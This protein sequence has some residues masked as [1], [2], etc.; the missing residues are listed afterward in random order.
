[1]PRYDIDVEWND[2]FERESERR[3]APRYEL[4]MKLSI[5]VDGPRGKG[6]W[7]GPGMVRDISSVGVRVLTKHRLNPSQHVTLAIPTDICPTILCL[8]KSFVGPAQVV[9]VQ[10]KQGR[11]IEAGLAYSETLL[12]NM[13]FAVFVDTLCAVAPLWLRSAWPRALSPGVY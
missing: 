9:R 8:P 7:V 2:P 4:R 5:L 12:Q 10:P 13:E 6:Q 1:M 3:S 11:I